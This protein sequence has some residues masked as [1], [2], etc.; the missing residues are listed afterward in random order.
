MPWKLK[1]I[2]GKDLAE[3]A[4]ENVNWVPGPQE[5]IPTGTFENPNAT[6]GGLR[7]P[8]HIEFESSARLDSFGKY[9][10][11]QEDGPCLE[12]QS[13]GFPAAPGQRTVARVMK[14]LRA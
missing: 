10:L 12:I 2:D 14:V 1:T 6:I 4:D 3:L 8:G 7:D 9:I 13:D 5:R 11:E